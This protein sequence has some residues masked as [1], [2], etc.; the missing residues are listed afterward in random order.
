MEDILELIC[1]W[2]WGPGLVFLL[3]GTGAL[4]TVRLKFVQLR[5]LRGL[6]GGGRKQL[7]TVCLS[8]GAAMGTGNITGV[9][10]ALAAGGPG[11]IF[12]MWVSAF[13]GMAIVYAEN[14]LSVMYSDGKRKGPM[15]Y[16]ESGLGSRGLALL[17]AVSCM[18]AAFGMGGMVQ[19]SSFARTMSLPGRPGALLL[20]AGVFAVVFF[21]ISGGTSRS[22][23]AAQLLLPAASALYVLLCGAVIFRQRQ[24]LPE[25]FRSIF[26][27]AFGL[28][29]ATGGTLGY[30]VSRA[31]SV[32]IRRGIFSNEAGLGSSP[33]LHST[34]EGS[35][36]GQQG[37]WSMFE[38]FFDT[39]FCC[40]LTA[41]T[42]LCA[43]AS[44]PEGAFALV[45]GKA[46]GPAVSAELAVFAFCT[47][48]GWYCCG[49]T[50]YRYLFPG[51]KTLLPRLIFAL[52]SASGA[53]VS[54]RAV[55]TLSDIFNGLMALPN[56]CGLI[57]LMKKLPRE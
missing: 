21:V 15:A 57:L 17:F 11:A 49:E 37:G 32:G 8:L 27:G 31:V 13:L 40:T 45:I 55:W 18:L 5:L 53:V 54:L 48:I 9:A 34:A 25:A 4:Y 39:I 20:A 43:G 19:V 24:Q 1:C 50:A 33:V 6:P 51:G 3:L 52:A 30:T 46:A 56:L 28:R 23:Q 16:L 26:T 2:V 36:P 14:E 41:L 38:V 12:W 10:A 42:L 22:G 7:R 47:M 35:A 29:Q 44:S